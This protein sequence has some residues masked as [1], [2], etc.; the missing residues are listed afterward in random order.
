MIIQND[1]EDA[2]RKL[3]KHIRQEP[4]GTFSVTVSKG[5][6]IGIDPVIFAD[7]TRSIEQTNSNVRAGQYCVGDSWRWSIP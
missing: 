5:E 3:E 2:L 7:L 4:D 1:Y 6:D